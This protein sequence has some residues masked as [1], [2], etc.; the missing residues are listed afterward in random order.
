MGL[1]VPSPNKPLNAK[2]SSRSVSPSVFV[3]QQFPNINTH[4]LIDKQANR[5]SKHTE[6]DRDFNQAELPRL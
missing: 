4:M 1:F 3:L 5:K 6:C 2:S